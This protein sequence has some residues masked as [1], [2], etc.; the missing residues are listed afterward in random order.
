MV[1]LVMEASRVFES[2]SHFAPGFFSQFTHRPWEGM[3]F[4]DLIQPLFMF[5]SGVAM[6]LSISE[7]KVSPRFFRRLLILF[8]LG[9]F[10]LGGLWNVLPQLSIGLFFAA[11]LLREDFRLQVGLSFFPIVIS[12]SLYHLYSG[13]SANFGAAVDLFLV[14]RTNPEGWVAW[15]AIPT[16]AHVIWGM[17]CGQLLVRRPQ[18]ATRY[19]WISGAIVLILGL[20][21]SSFMPV[22]KKIATAPFVLISGGICILAFAAVYTSVD[23]KKSIHAGH[24][25][26]K[27]F[28]VIGMNSILVYLVSEI[29]GRR[30]A[31]RFADGLTTAFL[32]FVVQWG[33][34]AFLARRKLFLRI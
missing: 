31:W 17:I 6:A 12:E 2:A 21:V 24:W 33:F 29:V 11:F 19:L 9:S 18:L 7:K 28:T 27:F 32:I 34:A 1:L 13:P 4:W 15:N 16:S 5:I 30:L 22:I 14:G 3:N 20:L 26:V 8:L 10:C 25:T 23:R